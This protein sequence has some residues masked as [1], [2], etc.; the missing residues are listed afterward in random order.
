[1]IVSFGDR[2]TETLYLCESGKVLRGLP[3]DIHRTARRDLDV[4]TA[5][6]VL[7]ELRSPPGD[8]LEALHGE[9]DGLPSPRVNDL[10]RVVS[11]WTAG[12]AA[13]VRIL[14]YHY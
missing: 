4:R 13:E 2:S 9:L 7:R 6:A 12:G 5:T 14:E 1:M 3:R 11:R 10:W 8:R